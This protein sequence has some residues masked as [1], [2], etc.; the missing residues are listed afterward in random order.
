MSP[1]NE[2]GAWEQSNFDIADIYSSMQSI[3]AIILQSH[4][5]LRT[6]EG[7]LNST[8]SC[9]PNSN[10]YCNQSRFLYLTIQ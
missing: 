8:R 9:Q 10:M 2:S 7:I 1:A 6:P 3:C 4:P 5:Q